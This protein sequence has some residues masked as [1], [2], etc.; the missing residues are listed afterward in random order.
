MA[1]KSLK[2]T[3]KKYSDEDRMGDEVPNSPVLLNEEDIEDNQRLL[4]N[5]AAGVA[6]ICPK[7]SNSGNSDGAEGETMVIDEKTIRAEITGQ[8]VVLMQQ[9]AERG[10]RRAGTISQ[11]Q[12]NSAAALAPS[13]SDN[14][15]ND[16]KTAMAAALENH[17][18]RTAATWEQYR[19]PNTLPARLHFLVERC[20]QR[21]SSWQHHALSNR[22]DPANKKLRSRMIRRI[23][24]LIRER[25]EGIRAP[26]TAAAPGEPS[27]N[28]DKRDNDMQQQHHNGRINDNDNGKV[29]RQPQKTHVD[30]ATRFAR[31]AQSVEG[32]LYGSARSREEYVDKETLPER[33]QK[34][35]LEY[36]G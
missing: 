27:N 15:N 2:A 22:V 32:A 13:K 4:D 24:R 36:H 8:I 11:P 17:L 30:C 20:R 28:D 35:A 25:V 1:T 19:D 23:M 12:K 29:N 34:V 31:M 21:K 26:E 9:A 14:N 7:K 5:L 33:M 10:A 3:N 6:G 18:F 16:Q